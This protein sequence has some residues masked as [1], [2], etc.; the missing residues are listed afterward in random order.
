LVKFEEVLRLPSRFCLV[1]ET[2]KT[3]NTCIASETLSEKGRACG[4]RFERCK[5]TTQFL[6]PMRLHAEVRADLPKIDVMR[7]HQSSLHVL[8]EANER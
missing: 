2:E 5:L 6:E 1:L 4:P 7:R 8:R 3:L